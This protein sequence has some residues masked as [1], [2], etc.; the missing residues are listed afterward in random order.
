[1]AFKKNPFFERLKYPQ[2]NIFKQLKDTFCIMS[3][4]SVQL[5]T[6]S[7]TNACLIIKCSL[8]NVLQPPSQSISKHNFSSRKMAQRC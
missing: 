1:M 5:I 8:Q 7:L 4:V 3:T 2:R 6:I